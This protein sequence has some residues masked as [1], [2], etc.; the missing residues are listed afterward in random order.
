MVK[1]LITGA[2][3]LLGTRL[4]EIALR[5]NF[6]VYAAYGEH[7]PL[8]GTPVYLNILDPKAEQQ[9]L[10]RIKPDAVVH[11]AALTDVDRCELEKE[12]AWKTN[13]EAT[14]NLARL[15]MDR[16]VFLVYVSTDYVFDGEKGMYKETDKPAPINHYGLTKL[17]GEEAVQALDDYCIARGSVIYGST[18]AT[19][20]TNFA[21]WLLDRLRKREE[22][23]IV[24]DQWNSPTLNISMAEMIIETLEK[25]ASGIFHLAGATRLSRY[26]FAKRLAEAFSL[27]PEFIT[28]VQSKQFEWVA[29]RP[30]D[31][32]LSVEKAEQTLTNKPLGIR[33]AIEKMKKET[34]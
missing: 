7:T 29:K 9:T 1:L 30:R 6:E 28:P 13:V 15:C 20:K 31:S 5:N 23:R 14:A 2:S 4:C 34:A 19:G 33:E 26:D 27:S 17:K 21:L 16:D 11:S 22:V 8:Y 12:L 3:G 24:T 25:R 18:P 10:D 32:S